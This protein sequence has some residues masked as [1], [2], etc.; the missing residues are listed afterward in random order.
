MSQIKEHY[1]N[2]LASFYSWMLGDF[3]LRVQEQEDFFKK[4]SIV[5]KDN[6][7]A[8]DL[9][10]GN[11]IQSVALA[12]LG[13][14]V[15]AIDFSGQLLDE[16]K[17]NSAGL[18]IQTIAGDFT[19]I[20]I[21]SRFSPSL[22]T[23]MGDTITHIG[24]VDSLTKLID[25][26]Y[27]ISE[28]DA[29]FVVSYRDLSRELEDTQRFIPVKADDKRILTCFLEYFAGYVRVTDLL[30][31]KEADK[32]IQ[33]VSSYQKLRLSLDTVRNLFMKNNYSLIDMEMIRGMNYLIFQK[34]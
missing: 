11:G 4:N 21:L 20:E 12:R 2:H 6:K 18:P 8:L 9:G 29:L 22:V 27:D 23:C 25:H 24:S 30:Y 13:F 7:V 5:P 15:K 34:R 26:V 10:A 17:S 14:D 31:E 1:D 19:D 16:L 3:N 28:K 32:W 33:K